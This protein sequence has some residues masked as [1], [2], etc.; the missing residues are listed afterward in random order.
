LYISLATLIRVSTTR[1]RGHCINSM[2]ST[3]FTILQDPSDKFTDSN[4]QTFTNKMGDFAIE[5]DMEEEV[6]MGLFASKMKIFKNGKDVTK[7]LLGKHVWATLP[8]PFEPVSADESFSFIP[9]CPIEHDPRLVILNIRTLEKAF[10]DIHGMTRANQF[11]RNSNLLLI[12]GNTRVMLYN[13]DTAQQS[14]IFIKSDDQHIDYAYMSTFENKIIILLTDYKKEI[15]TAKVYELDG[16]LIEEVT[17]ARPSELFNFDFEKYKR[18]STI[19]RFNLF[20]GSGYNF[21]AAGRMLNKWS[22]V[23]HNKAES[24]LILKTYVPV[25]EIYRNTKWNEEGCD[26]HVKTAALTITEM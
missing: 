6:R 26:I 24:T 8:R 10:I 23:N 5:Y 15:Q 17:I 9:T 4:P 20:N 2:T 12:T 1:N 11:A 16:N 18:L 19:D 25:S 21:V 3:T 7:Q 14:T 22:F 13:C